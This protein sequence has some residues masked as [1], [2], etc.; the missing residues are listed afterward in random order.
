MVGLFLA[1]SFE[2]NYPGHYEWPVRRLGHAINV[3]T[4]LK[5]GLILPWYFP[6]DHI[7]LAALS[8]FSQY[9]TGLPLPP[10]IVTLSRYQY[11]LWSQ[12]QTL[13]LYNTL[14]YST[15]H[16]SVLQNC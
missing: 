6:R 3:D 15:V 16:Y 5:I 4:K 2:E 1:F 9:D 7:H 11:K 8:A 12:Q 14:E 10:V 13:N